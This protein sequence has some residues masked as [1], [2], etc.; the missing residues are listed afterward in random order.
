MHQCATYGCVG[1]GWTVFAKSKK[2]IEQGKRIAYTQSTKTVVGSGC[3]A[4]CGSNNRLPKAV[5]L[6]GT[7][8]I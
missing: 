8:E 5:I 1:K 7:M 4:R 6:H 3:G 2:L